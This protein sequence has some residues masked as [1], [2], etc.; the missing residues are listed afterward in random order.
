MSDSIAKYVDQIRQ[1]EV[2]S[3]PGININQMACKIQSKCGRD[4]L[5]LDKEFTIFHVGTND[6]T[7]LSVEQMMS[8]YNNLITVTRQSSSTTIVVSAILPRPKDHSSLGEKVNDA[9][10]KL[11]VL[12]KDRHVQFLHAY[13]PFL[14]NRVPVRELFAVRD[15]GLHLNLEGVRRLH[16]FFI[17]S[18]AHLLK[19]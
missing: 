3:F 9:N 16:Q 5:I 17:N 2:I 13:R 12:C 19:G 4:K 1:C 15:Q 7:R 14:K 11:K 8:S 18:E 6:I 10:Q